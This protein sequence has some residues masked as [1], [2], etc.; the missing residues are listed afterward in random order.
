[1][2]DTV[3]EIGEKFFTLNTGSSERLLFKGAVKLGDNCLQDRTSYVI[4]PKN[5]MLLF[6]P[7]KKSVDFF[8]IKVSNLGF[9]EKSSFESICKSAEERGFCLISNEA[10]LNLIKEFTCEFGRVLILMS[11][12]F[13]FE[14]DYKVFYLKRD[15]NPICSMRSANFFNPGDELVFCKYSN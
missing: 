14:S 11:K 2:T 8:V 6:N 7:T 9:S 5:N 4:N 15:F 1:M 10:V 12:R 3:Q 13:Y